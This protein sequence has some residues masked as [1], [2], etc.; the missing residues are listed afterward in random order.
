MSPS[1]STRAS[2]GIPWITCSFT[3]AQI[4]AGNPWYPLNA[5]TAPAVG[6]ELVAQL[7]PGLKFVRANNSG[8][9]E[10]RTHRVLWNLEELPAAETGEVE[11]ARA[12]GTDDTGSDHCDAHA[13][14][15]S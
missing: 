15:S 13:F 14:H 5:G 3:D 12:G 6:V 9:Y 2:D 11:F 1:P 7:P 10:E 4:V 8:Y